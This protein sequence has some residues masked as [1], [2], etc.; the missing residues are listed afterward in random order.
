VSKVIIEH[1]FIEKSFKDDLDDESEI[2][3]YNKMLVSSSTSQNDNMDN[4]SKDISN[5]QIDLEDLNINIDYH[6]KLTP[7]VNGK[8]NK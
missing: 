1:F 5:F 2:N 4:S 3:N 7:G 8:A 6:Q